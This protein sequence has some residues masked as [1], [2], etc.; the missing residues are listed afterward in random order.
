MEFYELTGAEKKTLQPT[1]CLN[2][3]VKNESKILI[4][5]FDSV[6]NIIDSYCICDTG[7]TDNTVEVI[8]EYF[9]EKG[10]NG[11]IIF[12]PFQN[13]AH[14]RNVALKGCEGMS[15]YVLLLDADMKLDIGVFDKN[16]LNIADSFCVLQG[17]EHF[18]YYNKR[19]IKNNDNYKYIG[20]THEYI[21]NTRAEK[22]INLL[23]DNL[24][25]T[26]IGDGGS[27]I[28]KFIRD[29]ELLKN[30]IENEP[31]NTTR[32]YFY[33]ANSLFDLNRN[34]E[35]IEYYK[36]RIDRGDW[37]QEVW[38]SFYKIGLAYKRMGEIHQAIYYWMEGYQV[39]PDRIENLY[40]ITKYYREN[41]KYTL[42]YEY[43]KIAKNILNKKLNWESYLFLHN[44][45]YT[46]K[47]DQEYSIMAYYINVPKKINDEAVSVLKHCDDDS[48][49][50]NI[51]SNMKFY[52][53]IITPIKKINMTFRMEQTIGDVDY[54]FKSSTPCIIKNHD[55]GY[56]MNIRIVN[57][58]VTPAGEYVYP[59]KVISLNR[60][61]L[62]DN[63][64]QPV[65]E[66]R[67]FVPKWENILYLGVEDMKLF[68]DESNDKIIC[69]GTG[70]FNNKLTMAYS[71]YDDEGLKNPI[72]LTQYFK[73]S[74]CEKNWVFFNYQ[75]TP[76]IIY[77]WYPLT[78]CK[79]LDP[80]NDK[81]ETVVVEKKDMPKL[82]KHARGS[83][84]GCE[85]NNEIWFIIH[86]VSYESPRHYYH[87][88]VVFDKNMKLLRFSAPFKFDG[89]SIEY[90]LG[91]IVEDNRVICG[92]STWDKTTNIGIYDKKYIDS[93]I[94]YN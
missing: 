16:L 11:K 48:I 1:L 54:K 37:I 63:L 59:K 33:L 5:L 75:G 94:K 87:V 61:V 10:I 47:L 73:E 25:I 72:E 83:T 45:I 34:E 22:S 76:H 9:N 30:G 35:A 66:V 38:M 42:A 15:D 26:D 81:R 2:M 82:F 6:V 65:E 3:I 62:L 19:I 56:L 57:Y 46:Y 27:K 8:K 13:F 39:F 18:F 84:N 80:V 29:V 70:Y 20:V 85:Y 7:S 21:G 74:A 12:E 14:N 36:K 92:Y 17:T 68:H 41:S 88:F 40:E 31:E 93:I 43:Y 51:L 23:K 32:Y 28:N 53:D 44:D 67:T 86:I 77:Q 50:R 52:Q 78:I 58:R 91:L 89:L 55:N 4:R 24:F 60:T 49:I 90:C 69:H 64:F 71:I 79:I